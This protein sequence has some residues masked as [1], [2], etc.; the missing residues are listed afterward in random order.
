M[1]VFHYLIFV[2]FCSAP[3]EVFAQEE[4]PAVFPDTIPMEMHDFYYTTRPDTFTG[5]TVFH[6]SNPECYV[7]LKVH[8]EYISFLVFKKEK[9]RWKIFNPAPYPE[10]DGGSYTFDTIDFNG[11]GSPELLVRWEDFNPEN[12]GLG[13]S[14]E[15]KSG[16]YLWD[17]DKVQLI[18]HMRDQYNY[19]SSWSDRYID[20]TGEISASLVI[21][22][23]C[24]SYK[25]QFTLGKMQ[26]TA[27]SNC[28]ETDEE[29]RKILPEYERVFQYEVKGNYLVLRK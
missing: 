14:T 21:E 3:F 28:A 25:V 23:Y 15:Q 18:Y 19:S 2:L 1:R 5:D 26:I 13:W 9:K 27:D 29:S 12:G 6:L 8:M 22:A 24:R 10:M 7:L 16:F 11:K 17:I 20:T 4:Y